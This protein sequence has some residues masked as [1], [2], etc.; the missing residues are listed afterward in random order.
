M[1][2]ALQHSRSFVISPVDA[3]PRVIDAMPMLIQYGMFALATAVLALTPGPNTALTLSRTVAQGRLAGAL[4]LLGVELG[5]LV[6]LSAAIAGI[7]ALLLAIPTAYD[8]LH[9]VGAC[10]LLYVAGRMILGSQRLVGDQTMDREQ[11]WRLIGSGFASNALNPKTAAFYLSIF[12]Q[13]ILPQHGSVLLQG[14]LLGLLHIT[15][16]TLCNMVW[17]M[18]AGFLAGFLKHHPRWERAQRWLFGTI[19]GLFAMKL[20]AERRHAPA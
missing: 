13:F 16:S 18:G 9:I 10:Y 20:L 14:L 3:Q 7:T 19:I 17:V 2:A 1:K 15:V 8:G 6:H 5:F 12:P 4:V 11:P